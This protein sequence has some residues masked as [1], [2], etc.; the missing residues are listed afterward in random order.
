MIIKDSFKLLSYIF[1]FNLQFFL[2]LFYSLNYWV[3]SR[4]APCRKT[5]YQKFWETYLSQLQGRCLSTVGIQ[6]TQF[7]KFFIDWWKMNWVIK[8]NFLKCKN[9]FGEIL[10]SRGYFNLKYFTCICSGTLSKSIPKAPLR[11]PGKVKFKLKTSRN[12]QNSQE[13]E[14][15]PSHFQVVYLKV[16]KSNLVRGVGTTIKQAKMAAASK[17]LLRNLSSRL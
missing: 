15:N 16:H 14:T 8:D 11:E 7:G 9:L 4:S 6:L 1:V 13:N 5:M 17:Y 3:I 10:N 2:K 12:S